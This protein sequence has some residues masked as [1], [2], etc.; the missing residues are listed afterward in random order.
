MRPIEKIYFELTNICNF[1]CDFCSI[2]N[3][4][5]KKQF[6]DFSLFKKGIDEIAKEKLTNRIGFHILGEPLLYPKLFD[7]IEYAK[8]K[9]LETMMT[10]N[11][12]LL[13]KKTIK[14][15]IKAKLDIISISTETID[16]NKHESRRSGIEF[17]D[18]YNT[19]LN[20]VK[21]LRTLSK[22]KICLSLMNTA[23]KKY[24]DIDNLIKTNQ[25]ED[26]Y[27]EELANFIHDIFLILTKE[28]SIDKIK[29]S[30]KKI[31][32]N[33]PT[34]IKIDKQIN[35]YIQLFGD[36]GN[37]FTSKRI[38][39]TKIGFCGYALNNLGILSNGELT[40]CCVDY[41]GK[42]S[43][44]NLKTNSLVSLLSSE[45]VKSVKKSFKKLKVIH[46]HCQVCLGGSNRIKALLKGLLSIYF[47]KIKPHPTQPKEVFLK[48]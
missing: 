30:L 11:G 45:K 47:F 18:Y 14:K 21:K 15:L 10:T 42:T 3:S 35:I 37:A 38:Y 23:T 41:E 16:K 28:V 44:G 48:I 40:I 8:S 5:R 27:R 13:D 20:A 39:P 31:H 46:P 22:M 7:A 19:I 17:K 32:L 43:I 34:Y 36:W 6:M 24:F 29:K 26:N 2:N 1:K 33:Q 9:G 4:K 12:A 25:K